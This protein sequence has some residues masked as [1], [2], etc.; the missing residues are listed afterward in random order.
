[1]YCEEGIQ[2]VR[3]ITF[4]LEA[5]EGQDTPIKSV[6]DII[7]ITP[8]Q[9]LKSAVWADPGVPGRTSK[10]P[11]KK[12]NAVALSRS[13]FYARGQDCYLGFTTII[14]FIGGDGYGNETRIG[15]LD[16]DTVEAR[17]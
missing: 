10:D 1:M 13:R 15:Y 17:T 3:F 12:L 5:F 9:V 11:F 16:T 6:H 2:R 14:E 4:A 8:D 7:E